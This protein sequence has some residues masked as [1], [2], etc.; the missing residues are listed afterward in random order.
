ME[1]RPVQRSKAQK[2]M[3]VMLSGRVI[4]IGKNLYGFDENGVVLSGLTKVGNYWYYFKSSETPG[5]AGKAVVNRFV[6]LPDGRRAFFQKN[7]PG[8]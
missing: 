7:D 6:N 8:M 2:P 4:G 5:A 1:V 3:L